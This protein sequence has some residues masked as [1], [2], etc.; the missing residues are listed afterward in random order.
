M[1]TIEN[2]FNLLIIRRNDLRH[3]GNTPDN[4]P[5]YTHSQ[6]LSV[7]GAVM[8]FLSPNDDAQLRFALRIS[9][10]MVGM[11]IWDLCRNVSDDFEFP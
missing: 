1:F 6:N 2:L 9:E 3:A 11:W 8:E 4:T 5:L 7:S 10:S